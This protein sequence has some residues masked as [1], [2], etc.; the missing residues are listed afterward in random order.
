MHGQFSR[1][2][3]VTMLG[4]TVVG[5]RQLGDTISVPVTRAIVFRSTKPSSTATPR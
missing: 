4:G 3:I 2:T 5:H 1:R